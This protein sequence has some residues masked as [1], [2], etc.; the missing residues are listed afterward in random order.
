MNDAPL[1]LTL[2]GM[3]IITLV[4]RLSLIAWWQRISLSPLLRRGLRF[5]PPAVLAAIIFPEILQPGGALDLTLANTRLLAGLLAILI[6]WRT[7][8][9]LLTIAGGMAVLWGLDALI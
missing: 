6:A 4:T 1:W 8:S 3:G 7:K 2:V 5:V 9:A